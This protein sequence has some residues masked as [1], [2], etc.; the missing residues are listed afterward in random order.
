MT[1][2]IGFTEDDRLRCKRDVLMH[3]KRVLDRTPC[4]ILKVS[5]AGR[6]WEKFPT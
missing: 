1:S 4:G 6:F 5:M 3:A 2:T